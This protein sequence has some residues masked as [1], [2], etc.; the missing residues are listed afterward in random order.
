MRVAH[1]TALAHRAGYQPVTTGRVRD[2]WG[3]VR[4]CEGEKFGTTRWEGMS[5]AKVSARV[6]EVGPES[7]SEMMGASN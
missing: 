2:A 7:W 6:E 3:K 5:L 1:K 4:V